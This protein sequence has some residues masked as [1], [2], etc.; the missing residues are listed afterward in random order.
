MEMRPFSLRAFASLISLSF[1]LSAC[2]KTTPAL[3]PSFSEKIQ[4][5]SQVVKTCQQAYPK[6][7][8]TQ[9]SLL[10][11]TDRPSKPY[12]II[13]ALSVSKFNFLGV[14]RSQENIKMKMKSLAASIGG[15]AVISTGQDNKHWNANIIAFEKI[16]I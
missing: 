14:E 12:R 7:K 5:K 13:G 4:D 8:L 6:K 16:L 10:A 3:T 15:D 1:L 9:V 11:P 2:A